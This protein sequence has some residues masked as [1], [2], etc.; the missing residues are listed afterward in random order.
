MLV[1]LG[2]V[3]EP[4]TFDSYDVLVRAFLEARDLLTTFRFNDE[5]TRKRIAVWFKDK[6][7]DTWKPQHSVCE[8][9]LKTVGADNLQLA[10]RWGAISALAH[11]TYLA[12]Q[13]SVAVLS[14]TMRHRNARELILILEEKRADY[15]TALVS[16][17]ITISFE[18][19]GWVHIGCDVSR[20]STAEKLRQIGPVIVLSMLKRTENRRASEGCIW[21]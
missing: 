20:M 15:I 6:G 2:R 16:L 4:D 21:G 8:R 17:F 7:K 1:G 11:P 19:P 9:F 13:N 12:T 5:A 3:L 10:K 18:F 14:S